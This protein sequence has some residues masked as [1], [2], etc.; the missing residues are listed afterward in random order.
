MLHDKCAV[1]GIFGHEKAAELT[2]DGLYMLQHRGQENSGICSTDGE[3]I[4]LHVAKGLVRNV[5]TSEAIST[6]I[7]HAAIGHNLY[8]TSEPRIEENAQPH[9]VVSKKGIELTGACNGS[10]PFYN[11][12]R[13]RLIQAGYQLKSYSDNEAI[14]TLI[15]LYL[16]EGNNMQSAIRMMMYD[17]IDAAYS[18][19]ILTK[20][21]LW[22]VRD[23]RGFRPLIL[24]RLGTAYVIA[25]ETC[26][27]DIMGATYIRD[28]FP[29]EITRINQEGER[30][31]RE[32]RDIQYSFCGFEHI[33]IA[34]PDSL[35]FGFPVLTVRRRLGAK[36]WE[37]YPVEADMVISVPDSANE[38]ALGLAEASRIPFQIGLVRHHN[39]TREFTLP[40]QEIRDVESKY[41]HNPN[42]WVVN[43]KRIIVVDDSIVRGTAS[44][45]IIRMLRNAGAQ[46][47]HFRVSA[48]KIISPCFMGVDT[49]T[50]Q[51]LPGSHMSD[52]EICSSIEADTL[53]YMTLEGLRECLPDGK[54]Y[55]D[56][57]F[58]GKYPIKIPENKLAG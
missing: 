10:L 58:T 22:A 9:T 20:N 31:F 42:K 3:K 43:G 16:D 50:K 8:S 15:A 23:W 30:G 2:K 44:R 27:F 33:Y 36:L 40:N 48:V 38:A 13:E 56:A 57:C 55:C 17:L 34:R 7:G 12:L 39:T 21:E 4:Y 18:L 25:S 1:F 51:E 37:L 24:G 49:P 28:I 52:Q 54:K 41:K 53:G 6:L 19:V 46:K 47:I 5:F 32:E 11:D 14:L 29:G 35:V 45:K 26:A